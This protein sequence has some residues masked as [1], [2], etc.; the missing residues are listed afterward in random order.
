[1]TGE[2]KDILKYLLSNDIVSSELLDKAVKF[3]DVNGI[4]LTESLIKSKYIPEQDILKYVAVALGMDFIDLKNINIKDEVVKKVPA[5]LALHYGLMPIG[6]EGKK[7]IMASKSPI[8][9]KVQ[10]EIHFALGCEIKIVLALRSQIEK[11]LR[12]KYGLGADTVERLSGLSDN[13]NDAGYFKSLSEV[14]IED[15]DKQAEN[16]SVVQLVNQIILDG[17]NKRATDIHIEPYRGKLRIRFRIDGILQDQNVPAQMNNF[18]TA[19]FSRIKIMS[20]L[21]IVEH[22]VPQDGRAVVKTGGK[23]L[24]LRVS[25]M[26]TSHGESVVIRILS[27]KMTF[28]LDKLGFLEHDIKIIEELIKGTGGIIFLTGPTGAGKTTTLYAC[29]SKVNKKERK[30]I[31][32]EDPVEYEMENVTQIQVNPDVGLTFS[33]GLRS[34]LRH[35]PDI[36]MVGEVRDKETAEIAIRVALTGHLVFSTLHTNDA[37]TGIMRLVDIGIEPYLVASS[38]DA[39]IAQRLVRV[40][41]PECKEKDTSVDYEAIH[42]IFSKIGINVAKTNIFYK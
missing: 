34:V 28:D 11:I 39:F 21:D 40:I 31:T 8:G 15:L 3:S 7:L 13:V 42:S 26:P 9:I 6:L 29:L 23:A 22:R 30:I 32:I 27:T 4:S 20:N 24:D 35:D 25:V 38:V 37:V 16:I 19:I 18:S 1:M 12:T 14:D 36:I 41:C 5:R 17:C 10:D 2:D 33:A